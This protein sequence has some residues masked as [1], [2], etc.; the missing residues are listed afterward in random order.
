MRGKRLWNLWLLL[1]VAGAALTGYAAAWSPPQRVEWREVGAGSLLAA[2]V[3][4]DRAVFVPDSSLLDTI[5]GNQGVADRANEGLVPGP[6]GA[7]GL[8]VPL[9]PDPNAQRVPPLDRPY[10]VSISSLEVRP[11]D[12][13]YLERFAVWRIK[14]DDGWKLVSNVVPETSF[15]PSHD[16]AC[17]CEADFTLRLLASDGSLASIPGL[18]EDVARTWVDW[19]WDK[20]SSTLYVVSSKDGCIQVWRCGPARQ[21][22]ALGYLEAAFERLLGASADGL[23]YEVK[24][25][26]DYL[27]REHRPDRSDEVWAGR[28]VLAVSPDG[29]Y[30]LGLDATWHTQQLVVQTVGSKRLE[31][32]IARGL[33]IVYPDTWP[34]SDQFIALYAHNEDDY[35]DTYLVVC[36]IRGARLDLR[37][38]P[39][40]S[41]SL[42]FDL[43]V[44]PVVVGFGQVSVVTVDREAFRQ[45][46]AGN[47]ITWLVQIGGR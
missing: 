24:S 39:P 40:P 44:P 6:N 33:T 14:T 30:V 22:V 21:A 11:A 25:Q 37:L 31:V 17:V 27:V 32:E 15:S 16:Y 3:D 46:R 42:S 36:T 28:D 5:A 4:G 35:T 9:E 38:V 19:A 10:L 7:M 20:S 8:E 1:V 45:S 23:L 2:W 41:S 43:T 34:G 26:S 12:S 47:P 29:E 18:P 13:V